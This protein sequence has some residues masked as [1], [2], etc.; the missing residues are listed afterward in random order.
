MGLYFENCRFVKMDKVVNCSI[1]NYQLSMNFEKHLEEAGVEE[2]L[3]S[4]LLSLAAVVKQISETIK[5]ADTGKAGTKNVYGEEQLALD[6]LSDKIWEDAMRKNEHV[7]LI[8]SEESD[9]EKKFGDGEYAVC[10]DPLDGSSL[11]DVNLAVGTIFG[12]YKTETFLGKKGDDQVAAMIGVY[13]PRTTIILTVRKG[14]VEFSLRD[15]EFVLTQDGLKVGEGKMFAPGNLRAGKFRQEYVDLL[16]FWVKEQYTLRYS[17]GMVPDIN[18][19]LLKGKG[20]FAYPGY[21]DAPDGKLR[22]LF[23]C[24]PMALLMEE[25]GG[26]ASDGK[27]RILEKPVEKLEQRTPIFVGSKG[28]VERCLSF[29]S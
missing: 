11:V 27:I 1:V 18:Q 7:G 25:A 23:E 8:A 13:G 26:A 4:V 28:E 3:K 24:A 6:V 29:L 2:G 14:V 22:L 19:I 9:G 17:G 10:S 21:Q 20:I 5:T 16:N 15:G 12:I